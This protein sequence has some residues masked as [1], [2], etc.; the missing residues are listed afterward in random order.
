VEEALVSNRVPGGRM[1]VASI[2]VG[3]STTVRQGVFVESDLVIMSASAVPDGTLPGAIAVRFPGADPTSDFVT[4]ASHI[5]R[6][7]EVGF[8][9]LRLQAAA[10]L[11]AG[12]VQSFATTAPTVGMLL[13][14]VG[15]RA[16]GRTQVLAQKRFVTVRG[17]DGD[18]GAP[19]FDTGEVVEA[20]DAGL[21]CFDGPTGAVHALVMSAPTP[22]T[23]QTQFRVLQARRLQDWLS[24]MRLL[25]SVRRTLIPRGESTVAP[26]VQPNGTTSMCM[27]VAWGLLSTHAPINQFSCNFAPNQRYWLLPAGPAGH[28]AIVSDHSGKCVDVSGG[29]TATGTGL[30][31]FPCNFAPNQTFSAP[32]WTAGDGSRLIPD[33][34]PSM[35]VAVSGPAP[36]TTPSVPLA[37]APCAAASSPAV[38]QRWGFA[39]VR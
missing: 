3:G 36:N 29:A 2:L 22:A 18:M 26:F 12:F 17:E 15:F 9:A 28:F 14:C 38:E 35:C 1:P 8:V 20:R 34:A 27:D 13:N 33:H 39:L 37:L 32:R 24:A 11:R 10:P 5:N 19:V 23:S 4:T 7:H 16:D 25:A 21:A 30:Q 6:N 31:Q